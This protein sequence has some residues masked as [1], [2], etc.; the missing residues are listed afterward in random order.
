MAA[1][2]EAR[3]IWTRT[4]SGEIP[5]EFF[6]DIPRRVASR[7]LRT[8]EDVIR[9]LDIM[10]SELEKAYV[11]SRPNTDEALEAMRDLCAMVNPYI[12]EIE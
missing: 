1:S 9:A 7:E 11:G 12:E 8:R 4:L 10:A 6:D 3:D 2:G 5:S